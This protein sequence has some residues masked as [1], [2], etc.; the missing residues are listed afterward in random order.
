MYNSNNFKQTKKNIQRGDYKIYGMQTKNET[1]QNNKKEEK[2]T[3]NEIHKQSNWT[4]LFIVRKRRNFLLRNTW[5]LNWND[6]YWLDW[7]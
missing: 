7:L 2:I 3:N 4:L 1:K 5:T 6:D